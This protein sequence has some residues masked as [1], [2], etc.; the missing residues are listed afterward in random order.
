[1]ECNP[2][3]PCCE[4]NTCRD[5]LEAIARVLEESLRVEAQA[6][7]DAAERDLEKLNAK[8]KEIEDS[9]KYHEAKLLEHFAAGVVPDYNAAFHASILIALGDLADALAGIGSQ[10]EPLNKILGDADS[11]LT[12]QVTQNQD[13]LNE[14]ILKLNEWYQEETNRK[15][16][17]EEY[18]RFWDERFELHGNNGETMDDFKVRY[19]GI[20]NQHNTEQAEKWNALF[21]EYGLPNESMAEFQE[22]L[23][24][25]LAAQEQR[26]VEFWA[27]IREYYGCDDCV[28]GTCE[29]NCYYDEYMAA[30]AQ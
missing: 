27:G 7:R 14:F 21:A 24:G 11:Y 2:E 16:A 1:V 10:I 15:A 17:D 4:D 30:L 3:P 8:L 19:P 9:I 29:D 18:R 12:Y 22:R 5:C 23:P 20:V 28:D 6:I 26:R 13:A 25:V